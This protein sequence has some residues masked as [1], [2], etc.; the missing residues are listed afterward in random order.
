[1]NLTLGT[2]PNTLKSG[3]FEARAIF[4]LLPVAYPLQYYFFA[5]RIYSATNLSMR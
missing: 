3:F 1:M 5:H 2:H 4:H